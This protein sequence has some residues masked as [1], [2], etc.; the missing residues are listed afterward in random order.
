MPKLA[1][2][3]VFPIKSLDGITSNEAMIGPSGGLR[4]DRRWAMVDAEGRFINGKRTP[5]VHSIQAEFDLPAET[6]R[7]RQRGTTAWDSFHLTDDRKLLEAWLS[8]VFDMPVS[9]VENRESGFPDDLDAPGPTVISTQSL[10]TVAGWFGL[11]LDEARRRFRANLEIDAVAP[12]WEDHLFCSDAHGVAFQIGDVSLRGTNPCARCVVP[13]RSAE[14]GELT[15]LFSK[16]FAQQRQAALPS[17]AP[18][19]RFDHFYRLAVN[20]RPEPFSPVA[21]AVCVGD[22]VRIL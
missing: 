3:C 17:W 20:T 15:P 7:V 9:I 12:F 8:E 1:R 19:E 10:Q 13:S 5:L 4:Y 11:S 2:I 21:G 22:A 14:T 6:V 18:A 16:H